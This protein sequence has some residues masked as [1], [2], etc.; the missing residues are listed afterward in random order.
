MEASHKQLKALLQSEKASLLSADET[1]DE[2]EQVVELDQTRVGRLSRMDAMQSQAMSIETGRR[3][4]QRLLDIASALER[5]N[6]GDYGYCFECGESINP[7]R[8]KANPA[9]ALCIDCAESNE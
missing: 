8:L 6:N 7:G 5:I 4:R 2:A 9:A 1:G 3:R